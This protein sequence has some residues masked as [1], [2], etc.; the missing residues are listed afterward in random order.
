MTDIRTFEQMDS[1][2][3]LAQIAR[4]QKKEVSHIRLNT[5]VG[6]LVAAV[7]LVTL[8]VLLPRA[9]TLLDHMEQSLQEIDVFVENAD[10]M[11][12]EN[13][14][15]VADALGKVNA[16]DFDSLNKAIRDLSDTVHPLAEFAR[17]FQ[18]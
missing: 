13:A 4:Y 7:L 18:G 6:A 16:V 8:L 3:L 12:E 15:A 1:K 14:D 5:V 10:R 9:V 2:A 11:V 17:F